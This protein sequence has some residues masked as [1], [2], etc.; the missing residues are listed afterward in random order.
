MDNLTPNFIEGTV[1]FVTSEYILV[2]D[3]LNQIIRLPIHSAKCVPGDRLRC[4]ISGRPAIQIEPRRNTYSR[5]S[6]SF[7][8]R[9]QKQTEQVYAANLDLIVPVFAVAQP[10]PSWNMLDRYLVLAEANEIPALICLNK[11]DLAHDTAEVAE[12][13]EI[14]RRCGYEVVLTSASDP[15]GLD[16]MR[17]VLAQKTSLLL[18]KSGAGKTTLVNHL[19]RDLNE[20][21]SAVSQGGN[22]RGR[23][24]TSFTQLYA[25]TGGGFLVDTPGS[26]E[27]GLWQVDAYDLAGFF[28]EMRPHL[29]TCRF[30]ADCL[31]LEEPGCTVR[32]AVMAGQIHPYR[33]QS[34]NR[35]LEST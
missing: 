27:L 17:A 10:A 19:C 5:K 4:E 30:G 2:A 26:R 32:R 11:T 8:D 28:P 13:V 33:Y 29:G 31:H 18:G 24:T 35:M 3:Q 25:L 23:H 7:H 34:Y 22:Q 16:S 9:R 14:Y 1:T 12:R 15:T 20:K 6:S 21:T